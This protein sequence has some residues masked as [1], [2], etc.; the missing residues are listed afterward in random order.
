MTTTPST[1]HARQQCPV[2]WKVRVRCV[3]CMVWHIVINNLKVLLKFLRKSAINYEEHYV[4]EYS[5]LDNHSNRIQSLSILFTY[6]A[7]RIFAS[8]ACRSVEPLRR[9]HPRQLELVLIVRN[10]AEGHSPED[11][12]SLQLDRPAKNKHV[13]SP[14]TRERLWEQ[15]PLE[16]I[17]YCWRINTPQKPLVGLA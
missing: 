12:V 9:T 11:I 15:R 2:Q 17:R 5:A 13:L 8:A 4:D 3:K 10:D 6:F 14:A 16:S 7:R 1:R